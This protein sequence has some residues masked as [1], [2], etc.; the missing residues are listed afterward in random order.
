MKILKKVQRIFVLL[1]SVVTV[2]S[3]I[4]EPV[5]AAAANSSTIYQI[6]YHLDGGTNALKNPD[7]YTVE[8]T[9]TLMPA[10]KVGYDFIGWFLDENMTKQISEISNTTGNIELYAKFAAK[11]YMGVFDDNGATSSSSICIKLDNSLGQTKEVSLNNGDVFDPY[12]YWTPSCSG[13]VFLG[14]HNNSKL[15]SGPLE[16]SQ[17]L[18]LEAKW[19]RCEQ[20][21]YDGIF[22]EGLNSITVRPN[23]NKDIFEDVAYVYVPAG[24]STVSYEGE[25]SER[26]IY[27][28]DKYYATISGSFTIY[29]VTHQKV[30]VSGSNGGYGEK[31]GELTVDPGTLL[32]IT[33]WADYAAVGLGYY[34]IGECSL[35]VGKRRTS[36]ITVSNQRL[37]EQEFDS[38]VNAPSVSKDGYKLLGWYDSQGNQ[39]TDTWQYTKKQTFTAKWKPLNY[40][41]TYELDGGANTAYNPSVYTIEDVITLKDPIKPGYTFKGWYS[42]ANFRTQVTSISNQ[43]GNITL[44]A[45]WEVNSYYLT[46]DASNGVWAPKVTFVSDGVEVKCCYLYEQD[47]ITAYRPDD[48]DGYIFAGWYTNSECTSLFK[49]NGTITD[50]TTLYAKWVECNSNTVNI[51]SVGK[52]N[53]TIQGKTEQLYAFVPLVDGKITVTSESNNLDLYGILYDEKKNVLISADDISSTDLDFTYKYNV[54]AGQIYYISIKGNT[55][56]TLGEAIV[57]MVWSGDCTI[58]GTTYQNRQFTVVYDTNYE[59]PSKPIRDGYVFMGW[60]DENNTQ[61]TEGTWNFT[62]D[63]TLTANWETATYHTVTFKNLDG[64]II[65]SEGYYLGEDIVAPELPTKAPDNTYTYKAKWDNGYT[66]V[67]TGDAVYSP[68]F[69]PTYIDYTIIFVNEDGT[70]LS[71]EIYHWGDVVT[72]PTDPT[73]APDANHANIY[74]FVGWNKAVVNCA[75]DTTYTATYTAVPLKDL[76]VISRPNQVRYRTGE[77]LNLAGLSVRL[78]YSDGTGISLENVDAQFVNADLSTSGRKTVIVTIAGV[79]T[80]FEVYVHDVRETNVTVDSSLYPQSSHD[81][82]N[83]MDE[84]KTFTYP[85]AQSLIITFNSQTSVENNYD[86]IYI[87]DGEGNQIAKYTG[88]TAANKTLTILG[89]SFKIRLTSDYSNVKYGYAFSSIQANMKNAGEIVHQPVVDP[90]TVTCTQDGLTEGSHCDIC[91]DVL[92]PQEEVSAP[93]HDY[94]GVMTTAP[95]C[96]EKGY[97]TYTCVVCNDTYVTD[98]VDATGHSYTEEITKVPTHTEAGEK[99]FTCACGDTYTEEIAVISDHAYIAAETTAPTCTETGV[100]TYTCACGDTYTE[101][102]AANGHALT[103]VKAKAPTCT[104]A[105]YEAYEFCSACD[106]T[107]YAEVAATG[108]TYDAVVTAPTCTADGYTTYTCACGDTYTDDVVAATGH[109]YDAVVTA[110][111]CTADGYTTYTCEC[112]NSYV[113][114]YVDA[115]GHTEEIIPA[116]DP[117]T[118]DAGWKEGKKCSVCDKILVEQQIVPPLN[119]ISGTCGKNLIW[120][121]DDETGTLTILGIGTMDD[122]YYYNYNNRPWEDYEDSIKTIVINDGV[123]TIGDYAFD[124]CDN[125]TTVTIPDSVTTIGWSAFGDCDSLTTVT[126]PDSVTTIGQRAFGDCD[127]LTSVTIPDSVTYIGNYAFGGCTRLTNITVDSDN[128]YYS[129][130]EYGVLFNK[131]KTTLIQYPIGNTRE[132][133]TIPDSVTTIGDYAFYYCDS[134]TSVTIGDGVTSIGYVAFCSCNSLTSVTIGDGVT[135]IGYA[136]FYDCDSLTSVT[137]PDSVTTIGD[138]AFLNCDNL[139]S[140][141]IG[142]SV[143]TI[144]DSAFQYCKRLTSITVDSDNKY[145]SNDEY[146]VLF[147][148][149]KT[150]LIQYPIGNTR[151]SYTIPDSVTTIGDYAFYYCDS[152][153]SV[154]IGDGVTSIGYAAFRDCDSLT[155]VTIPESVTTIGDS[156]FYNCSS[157]TSVTIPE[158]VTTIGYSAFYDCYSL[159]SVTIPE[160][161]TTIDDYAFFCCYSLTDVYYSG[162]EAQWNTIGIDSGNERLLNA[163]IHYNNCNGYV[164]EITPPTCMTQ[165]YTTYTCACGRSYKADYVNATGHDYTSEITTPATH[166]KDGVETFTCENCKDSYTEIIDR[167]TE[168]NHNSVVTTPTCEDIGYTTYTCECGYIYI[169]DYV[170]A[171]GHTPANAIEENY[172]APTCTEK[173][174]KDVV[175]YCSACDEE[176]NRETVEIEILDHVDENNDGYCDDCDFQICDHKCH[177]GGFFWKI[178]LFFN[179]LFK[180]NKYCSCG[181]AHY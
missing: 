76:V 101:E 45:K 154:T 60:Y 105:G 86:Y 90:A 65:S 114:N 124:G 142:N 61:I 8:D 68:I 10:T 43:T 117:T 44:Y 77:N 132:S 79:C 52:V 13:Y 24:I 2:F 181:V 53:T 67:C 133:Y 27:Y 131:N 88:T 11:S 144:G 141:T 72:S 171:L 22:G 7:A 166:L 18:S 5:N 20:T 32:R 64:E 115:V 104:V 134:L 130:D 6:T 158:S 108:H 138:A 91:G 41:I 151:E 70:E 19:S 159:T 82:S 160:S 113:G 150:T 106:Y 46:L 75:G 119:G 59:L 128:K 66:G 49:F 1:L 177:K 120:T 155:S 42:D 112:G 107:T 98:Y 126:I 28:L 143:T 96:T 111:I 116:V 87:Y 170:N 127:S 25:S 163:K 9:I 51:E 31:S 95:T 14:W 169:A 164:G 173:G 85:G 172:V 63:K 48:K 23:I 109:D 93:G 148:K 180:S 149:N 16:I 168:H 12:S 121:F 84:T 38:M 140:V 99:T 37:I 175:V 69:E 17:D 73:K 35:T 167:I 36:K 152:L 56:L 162:T 136:A 80:Q 100:M 161:V 55:S 165:G 74:T 3:V 103:V 135:S 92:V 179:K 30:L 71:K 62:T 15:V 122:Y 129:S 39:M 29:D 118:S 89:D 125:L 110:P 178:T 176:L 94:E 83:N 26:Y 58:K 54:K 47:T 34:A 40:D 137:I 153:T 50:D 139:T 174:S 21:N 4:C 57:N 157:L 33:T 146:G 145:F 156:A 97:T 78:V 102:I 123:T 147:N 81:Y